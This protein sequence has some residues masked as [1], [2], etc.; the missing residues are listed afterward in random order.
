MVALYALKS[1]PEN[2]ALAFGL[3]PASSLADPYEHVTPASVVFSSR[4]PALL[5]YRD[6][7]VSRAAR[8]LF[9]PYYIMFPAA[10]ATASLVIPM[11]EMVEFERGDRGR[12]AQRQ[13]LPLS[14][15]LDVQAGQGLQVY[16]ASV[17][18]VAR[19]SGLRWAMYNHRI[20]SFI[21]GTT[22]FWIAEMLSMGGAWLLVAQCVSGGG[23]G[24]RGRR[25]GK[26]ASKDRSG[27]MLRG[28][29]AG[30][31]SGDPTGM[32]SSAGVKYEEGDEKDLD[33]DE[34][35]DVKVKEEEDTEQEPPSMGDLLRHG[36]DA[37]DEEDGDEEG[38]WKE[39]RSGTSGFHRDGKGGSIRRRSSRGGGVIAR[40]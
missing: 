32:P 35:E 30:I 28:D 37:D 39:S 34:E 26:L 27:G 10:E 21:A 18:L 15:L 33:D 13:P 12:A 29:L 8:L 14:V 7:L 17:T 23:G 25:Q 20:L 36:G 31:S 19:L 11:G 3:P 9:L 22:A 38:L 4:R 2:P 40:P 24:G 5:P 16:S 1:Q 6:P